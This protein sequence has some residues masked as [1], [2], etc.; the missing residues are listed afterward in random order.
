MV[1]SLV[2]F[3]TWVSLSQAI[4]SFLRPSRHKQDFLSPPFS[5][6]LKRLSSCFQ[7]IHNCW[8]LEKFSSG[9]MV[10]KKLFLLLLFCQILNIR[11]EQ[12]VCPEGTFCW[13]KC[14]KI[15]E[16]FE[17]KSGGC[18]NE[19]N[20]NINTNID[21]YQLFINDTESPI[22][23]GSLKIKHFLCINNKLECWR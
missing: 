3:F 6:T 17:V 21:V 5:K 7:T 15:D 14:C 10:S 8:K 13:P 12:F 1:S 11:C 23:Q 4:P 19:A 22:L 16:H 20:A 18:S 9:N 2:S